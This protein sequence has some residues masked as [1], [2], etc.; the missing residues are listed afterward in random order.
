M[1]RLWLA[2]LVVVSAGSCKYQE[3]ERETGYKGRAR[4]NPW[5][6]AERFAARQGH[7]VRSEVKWT[8][9]GYEDAAC[10]VPA[11]MLGNRVFAGQMKSWMADGGHLVLLVENAEAER[12]DWNQFDRELLFDDALYEFLDD[13]G[14]ELVSGASGKFDELTLAGETFKVRGRS[15]FT[16]KPNGREPA[17]FVHAPYGDGKISVLC[18][19]SL[20][21]NRYIDR[22]E[23]AGF[24]QALLDASDYEGTVLFLRGNN[25]SF[26]G[27]IK[28]H[29]WPVLV[30]FAAC[31]AVWLWRGFARFGPID[32][33]AEPEALRGYAGHLEATGDFHW[34]LDRAAS[35]LTPQRE[36]LVEAAQR[37]ALHAGRR[38]EDLFAFL[39][40]RTGL[41]RERVFTALAGG[42]GRTTEHLTQLA[43]D[44]QQLDRHLSTKHRS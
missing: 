33:Q 5:L 30:A 23:H 40:E 27:M 26:F 18:D 9:P 15:S 36:R 19:A 41:S 11:E 42:P 4:V 35:L 29:L 31:L 22:R 1:I 20:L 24:F 14:M 10:F 34:R 6:A 7:E 37:A 32:A 28:Q 16:V 43:A 38:D 3:I 2:L 17:P 21:R 8:A 44:L 12:N 39:S 13:A 25:L